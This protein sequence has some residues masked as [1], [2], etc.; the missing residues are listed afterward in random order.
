MQLVEHV[1]IFK[2]ALPL[3]L[4][5]ET[6]NWFEAEDAAG[7]SWQRPDDN[8]IREDTGLSAEQFYT[9]TSTIGSMTPPCIQKTMNYFWENYAKYTARY[10]VLNQSGRHFVAEIKWQRTRPTE[11][12]HIWHFENSDFDAARRL[13][14]FMFYL[15]DV[16]HGGETEFLYQSLRIKPEAGTLVIW[17]ASY[18]HTHRGNPPLKETKYIATGWIEFAGGKA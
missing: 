1:G 15:N 16:E 12:Y 8:T 2:N 6:I 13:A 14:A 18:T 4:C 17:P 9:R 7:M 3:E 10:G 11:G 5:R